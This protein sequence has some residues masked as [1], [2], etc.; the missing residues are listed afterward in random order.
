MGVVA[1]QD[2]C[3]ELNTTFAEVPNSTEEPKTICPLLKFQNDADLFKT[4]VQLFVPGDFPSGKRN[5]TITF[6]A[7]KV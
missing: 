4:A 1:E 7:S 3:T 6:T 2:S 5:T